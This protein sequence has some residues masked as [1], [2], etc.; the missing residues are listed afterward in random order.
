M[1]KWSPIGQNVAKGWMYLNLAVV[2]EQITIT[3]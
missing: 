2:M 3:D 1:A